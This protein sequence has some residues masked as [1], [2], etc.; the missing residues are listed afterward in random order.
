M[1]PSLSLRRVFRSISGGDSASTYSGFSKLGEKGDVSYYSKPGEIYTMGD[2][3]IDKVVYGFYRDQLFG[4]Y[5]NLDS[6]YV[7]DKLLNHMKS[8]FGIPSYKTTASDL[9]VYKWKQQDITIKLKMNRL[10]EKMKLAFYYQPFSSKV[11]A[12]QW[13]E[14]DTSSFRFVPI[15]KN[16]KPEKYVLFEF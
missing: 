15:D 16:K 1:L 4:I 12:K 11:N 8:Q 5:F 6:I 10:T 13:E 9:I 3:S 14:L 2:V 7:Y